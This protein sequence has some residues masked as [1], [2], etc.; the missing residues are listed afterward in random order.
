MG[1][2]PQQIF[3]GNQLPK[4]VAIPDE[5]RGHMKFSSRAAHKLARNLF[6]AMMIYQQGLEGK[7]HLLAKL[8]NV[9]TDLFSMS[10]ACAR[11]VYLYSQ[12]PKDSG[13]LELADLF[14]LQ[15]RGRIKKQFHGLF[16]NR[17][18]FVYQVA[19]NALEGKYKW[20]E[21]DIF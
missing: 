11:A 3:H 13:P 15:A 10:A 21:T 1:W 19:Q 12:N 20:L 17:D 18:K 4:D 16:F 8:V 14:C 5:L 2:Y 6:H 7:Q 9:G